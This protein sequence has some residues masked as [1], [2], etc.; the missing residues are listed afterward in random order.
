MK[1]VLLLSIASVSVSNL[2]D[3]SPTC[4][5][6]LDLPLIVKEKQALKDMF[7]SD[8]YKSSKYEKEKSRRAAYEAKKVV[9]DK[10]FWNKATEILKA[11]EPIVKVLKLVT[12]NQQWDFFMKQLI[13]PSKLLRK[14][15]VTV[16]ITIQPLTKDGFTCILICIQ[17]ARIYMFNLFILH[18]CI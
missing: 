15:V 16:P 8:E 9:M 18:V 3:F 11:F 4:T 10:E 6:Y 13:E 17:R 14:I 12:I 1:L 5:K 2:A 7:D